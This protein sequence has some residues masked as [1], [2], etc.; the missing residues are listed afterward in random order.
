[1]RHNSKS[2][3]A[4]ARSLPTTF[5]TSGLKCPQITGKNKTGIKKNKN[6]VSRKGLET[7]PKIMPQSSKLRYKTLPK[8]Q[9]K[10]SDMI[11]N[12]ISTCQ[13]PAGTL[14]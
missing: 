2:L 14:K 5:D 11:T 3:Q 4:L 10:Q 7:E 13:H 12:L 9:P 8:S 6:L 1:M